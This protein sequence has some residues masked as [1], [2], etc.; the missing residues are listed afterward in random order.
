MNSLLFKDHRLQLEL[1]SPNLDD[2]LFVIV[3]TLSSLTYNFFNKPLIITEIF[4]NQE[5][6]DYYYRDVAGYKEKPWK[7]VH[8]FGRGID[9]RAKDFTKG[10]QS[11]IKMFLNTHFEYGHGKKTCLIHEIDDGWHGHLQVNNDP[12]TK[13]LKR[14]Q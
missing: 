5:M 14:E 7:S 1:F 6:Q 13:L 4:R 12:Y 10:E 3:C 8:Q 2:R 11:E 9:F